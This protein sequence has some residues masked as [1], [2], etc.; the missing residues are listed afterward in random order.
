[1][2]ESDY[3]A[4]ILLHEMIQP[5]SDPRLLWHST[6]INRKMNLQYGSL[7]KPALKAMTVIITTHCIMHVITAECV[8]SWV[9][10]T[11]ESL[12]YSNSVIEGQRSNKLKLH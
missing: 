5:S 7:S 10:V 11:N 2:K 4:P 1:M 8:C 6:K 9:G 12:L 3:K